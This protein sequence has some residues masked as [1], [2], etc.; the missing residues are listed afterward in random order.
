[1]AVSAFD[2]GIRAGLYVDDRPELMAR[3]MFAMHQ[4]RLADWVE[5][6]M[7]ESVAEVTQE[8]Q[9]QFIR[10]FC[11]PKFVA[12]WRTGQRSRSQR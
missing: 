12:K 7:K 10:A 3:T 2:L 9:E 11:T 5:R 1:M 4:V 8:A 6:G